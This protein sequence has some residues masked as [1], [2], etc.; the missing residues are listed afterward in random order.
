MKNVSDKSCTEN[1]NTKCTFNNIPPPPEN[2]AVYEI[3]WGD[4]VQPGRPHMTT[5]HGACALQAGNLGPQTH[6]QNM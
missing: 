2:R 3:M 6:T 5:Q 4:I 1:Q